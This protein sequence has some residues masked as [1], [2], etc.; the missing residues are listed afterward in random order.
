MPVRRL[1]RH[2]TLLVLTGAVASLLPAVPALASGQQLS[3]FEDDGHLQGNP[4]ATLALLRSLGVGVIRVAV[5]WAE[6]APAKLPAHFQPSNPGD[7]NYNWAI[8]DRIDRAAQANGITADFTL[9]PPAPAWSLAGG[10]PRGGG[11]HGQWKPSA[12]EFGAFVR[13]V[14]ARYSG[15]YTAPGDS[16][17]LPKISFWAIWNEPN[18][19]QDLGPQATKGS[20]VLFAPIMYRSLLDNAW[21][22]LKATGHSRDT[23]LIGNLAARGTRSRATRSLRDGRPGNFGATKP[24]QF[25]RALYCVDTRN[26]PLKGSAAS[27]E[28]CPT[29]ASASRRFRAAHP[30]LFGATGFAV[31][32][33]PVNLPPN[34]LDSR[35]PDYAELGDLPHVTSVLDAVQ[36]TYG[37]HKRYPIYITEFGYITNPPNHSN[38]YPSPATAAYWIN[39]A[40][41]LMWRNARVAT[42]MQF[43]LEDPNPRVNVPEFGGFADGLEYFG[44]KHKPAYNAYRMPLYLPST[45]AAR[46][47][48]LEVW[49]AIRPAHFAQLDTH[50]AQ[51]AQIQFQRGSRGAFE[52]IKTVTITNPRGY[53]DVKVTFPASGSVRLAWTGP[54][55]TTPSDT[56]PLNSRTQKITVR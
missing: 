5:P 19:G 24:L 51:Q 56:T 46:G 21:S 55:D 50:T 26:R 9:N 31:H 12:S 27:A 41:Y 2:L 42:S 38:H 47:R 34:Q 32:P 7:P 53:F 15:N 52:T 48:S 44:G 36:R 8:F 25:V 3:V 39:W 6:I 45:Q 16:S 20:S 40:E 4:E 17:P 43:L 29:N 23:I 49:G 30:A 22:S 35:D 33:Y 10:V 28:S 1:L 18:F 37:S 11:R 54:V 14:G 13:A